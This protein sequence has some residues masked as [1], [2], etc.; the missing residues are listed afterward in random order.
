MTT[1][2]EALQK[3]TDRIARLEKAARQPPR[4]AW[5]PREIADMTGLAKDA[6]YAAIRDGDLAAKQI[7]RGYVVADT[8]LQRWLADTGRTTT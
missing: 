6:V 3:L 7:G 4:I 5:R 8:E 2:V 1:T